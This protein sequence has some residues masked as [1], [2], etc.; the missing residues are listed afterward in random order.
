M[1]A[2][3]ETSPPEELDH[4]TVARLQRA[5]DWAAELAGFGGGGLLFIAGAVGLVTCLLNWSSF[6]RGYHYVWV[7]LRS[8][9]LIG[10]VTALYVGTLVL[11]SAL[12]DL[13][14][15]SRR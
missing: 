7:N 1:T 5:T 2:Q 3:N 12:H 11:R 10:S 4:K 14:E 9:Y 15:R 8:A 6:Y 13:R